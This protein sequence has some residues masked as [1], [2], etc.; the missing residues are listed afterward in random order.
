MADQFG[1]LVVVWF[2]GLLFGGSLL[3]NALVDLGAGP[4]R[5]WRS[6]RRDA[7][8]STPQAGSAAGD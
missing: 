4:F 3:A 2:F 7:R 8:L 6:A 1:S 5:A